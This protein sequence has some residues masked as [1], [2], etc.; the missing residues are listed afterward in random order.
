EGRRA[1]DQYVDPEDLVT[2]EGLVTPPLPLQANPPRMVIEPSRDLMELRM[3]I[4]AATMFA[5]I[6]RVQVD[7]FVKAVGE[8]VANA[9]K[10]GADPV[11][12]RLW[13]A[14]SGLVCTVTDQGP[15][16][17]DPLA[18]YARPGSPSEGGLGLWAARQLCDVLDYQ[19][20]PD[21]FTVRVATLL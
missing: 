12:L 19:H 1:N 11:Q 7:D 15:G 8:V 5:D 17:A 20:G 18:G 4:Y 2:R 16:I 3:E 9:H 13:A 21:G 10:H 6:P 14:D